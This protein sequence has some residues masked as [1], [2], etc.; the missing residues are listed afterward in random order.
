MR[1][2]FLMAIDELK[3][4]VVCKSAEETMALASRLAREMREGTVALTGNLGAGKTTFA[5][6]LAAGLGV[7]ET[8][9][10]PSYNVCL[11]YSG[12]IASFAHVDAYRLSG[13]EAFDALL[14]DEIL[15][16]PKL[17]CV[18]WADIVGDALPPDTLWINI[19]GM[20]ERRF[21]LGRA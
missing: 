7:K 1:A 13:P 2:F 20:D 12:E 14:L 4:G 8:V 10:S 15:P 5:K 19:S 9:K 16:G 3:K 11:T 17:V 18:E 21:V 6:G